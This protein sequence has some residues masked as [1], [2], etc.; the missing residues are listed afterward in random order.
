MKALAYIRVSTTE[1]AN[2]GVSLDAQRSA[3]ESY[4]QLRG[5]ELEAVFEDAAVS[6]GTPLADRPAGA[7]LVAAV[8]RGDG[9]A[10]V[11]LKLDRLF[12]D[13]GDCLDVTRRWD[14]QGVALHL[15][16]LGGQ[17]IDTSTAMGRM[18]LTMLAGF[19]EMER[20]LI[21][22]RTQAAMDHKKAKGERVGHIPFGCTVAADGVL[23]E[24]CPAEQD[25]I[26]AM[27]ARLNNGLSLRATARS[28]NEAGYTNRGRPWSYSAVNRISKREAS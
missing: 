4:C 2:E 23:L 22:E 25:T 18:F 16:D 27:L 15:I 21:R 11:A 3:M 1:Q 12:R 6:A 7:E 20:N 19:A 9:Q 28:L 26:E 5:M 24:V 13:A 8:E 14:G 17:A 10:V